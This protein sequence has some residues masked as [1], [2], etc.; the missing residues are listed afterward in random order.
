MTPDLQILSDQDRFDWLRL[1]RSENIGPRTFL[2]LMARFGTAG[3]AL[4]ALPGLGGRSVKIAPVRDIETEM[5]AARRAGVHFL[6]LC[7]PSYPASLRAIDTA[8]PMLAVKGNLASLQ[9]PMVAMVGSRNASATGLVMTERLAR[10]LGEAGYVVVSGLARG[11]D[12]KAHLASLETG[13]VA[14][15]AGGHARIYPSEHAGT[16]DR[17]AE[18]GAVVSEMPLTWEPRARDF[19]RRNRIVS[20][21]ALGLIVVEAAR[22]SGSLIT[23]RFANEQGRE[24]FAVP[25]S[26]LDPRAEGPNALLKDGATFCTSAEDV[27]EG[28]VGMTVAGQSAPGMNETGRWGFDNDPLWDE[29]DGL[30]LSPDVHTADDPAPAWPLSIGQ[31][32]KTSQTLLNAEADDERSARLPTSAPNL[33]SVVLDLLGSVPLSIDDV[34]R[35]SGLPVRQVQSVLMELEIEG[36]IQRQGANLVSLVSPA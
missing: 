18:H 21:M 3:K 10:G 32:P 27:L 15:L 29:L 24:I 13:T 12:I 14:V 8:P 33:K 23:A 31:A 7:E 34:A 30:E 36:T 1:I 26:P 22:R 17:I 28:L 19:P 5:E 16:V 20:G 11:I 2:G 25:G 9:R 4:E 6:A 35:V